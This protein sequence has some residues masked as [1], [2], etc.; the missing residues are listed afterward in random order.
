MRCGGRRLGST[1]EGRPRKQSPEQYRGRD[2]GGG[3]PRSTTEDTSSAWS[4]ARGSLR[5]DESGDRDLR[6]GSRLAVV[7]VSSHSAGA[8][9][10]RAG[11]G[12]GRLGV[13]SLP[14]VCYHVLAGPFPS[15]HHTSLLAA[16]LP[17]CA[18]CGAWC[19]LRAAGC[20]QLDWNRSMRSCSRSSTDRS[21]CCATACNRSC[22]CSWIA[23]CESLRV[24]CVSIHLL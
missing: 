16:R 14:V 11:S 23:A 9:A 12:R 20:L 4:G 19:W 3:S 2:Q 1:V 8:R 7:L 6:L 18:C 24:L 5:S 22:S 10:G 21:F 17:A 13:G 15:G